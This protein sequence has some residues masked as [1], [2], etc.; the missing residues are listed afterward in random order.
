MFCRNCGSET[1]DQAV[2]CV[3]CGCPP[4]KG[5]N[6]CQNCGAATQPIQVVCVK[7]GVQLTGIEEE[8]VKSQLAAGLFGI[9]LPGLG[10]HRFY[11][12]Y[13]AIGIVQIVVT[14][15]TLGFG[16]I[17]GFIEGIL[18]L[19]GSMDKDAQGRP[20]KKM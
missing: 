10:I 1:A 6:Y 13:V 16:A 9:L 12:G 19:A 17:W 3:K 2:I 18:I 15:I 7:C 20:L 4:K 5:S 14:L 11:L 8:G